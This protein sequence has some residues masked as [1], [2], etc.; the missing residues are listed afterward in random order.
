[1]DAIDQK[2]LTMLQKNARTPL[3]VLAEAVFLSS[4]AVSARIRNLEAQ[5]IL[6]GYQAQVDQYRLGYHIRA[7]VLLEMTPDRRESFVKQIVKEPH[8]LECSHITGEYSM[9]LKVAFKSTVEL[10]GFVGRLQKFGR[11]QTQIVFSTPIEAR[12]VQATEDNR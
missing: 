4:P 1:M 2:I 6:T 12:G 7:Y 10:D 9:L 5:G 8:V 3:K 11:T